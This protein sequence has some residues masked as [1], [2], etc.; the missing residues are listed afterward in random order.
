MTDSN[1]INLSINSAHQKE[2]G[3]EMTV[4]C[5]N[6]LTDNASYKQ[7]FNLIKKAK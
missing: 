4:M 6:T 1:R 3:E 2:V 7:L 5:K